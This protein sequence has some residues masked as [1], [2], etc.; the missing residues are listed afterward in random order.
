MTYIIVG[1]VAKVE[2]LQI[3]GD[4]AENLGGDDG[5]SAEVG[6]VRQQLQRLGEEL[7]AG[8]STP[9]IS[10]YDKRLAKRQNEQVMD[11]P[12]ARMRHLMLWILVEGVQTPH[13]GILVEE[14]EQLTRMELD[15]VDEV[16]GEV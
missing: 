2:R 10:L 9:L 14:V 7:T 3:Q 8:R 13:E 6:G 11:I 12:Q 1:R 4:A 15:R 16:D 5:I